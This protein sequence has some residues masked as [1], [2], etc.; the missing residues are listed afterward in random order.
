MN[1]NI[2][3]K[4]L[5]FFSE[6]EKIAKEKCARDE[7]IAEF[8]QPSAGVPEENPMFIDGFFLQPFKNLTTLSMSRIESA[9]IKKLADSG[10]G[11]EDSKGNIITN[12][13]V[14][15]EEVKTNDVNI[16]EIEFVVSLKNGLKIPMTKSVDEFRS[17]SW[18][19]Y[20][21]RLHCDN[22]H[23]FKAALELLLRKNEVVVFTE[24]HSPGWYEENGKWN[25]FNCKTNVLGE[26]SSIKIVTENAGA[27]KVNEREENL[28][29]KFWE[30]QNLTRGPQALIVMAY[31]ILASLYS[32]FKAAG[33]LPKGVLALIGPQ[34]TRKTSLALVLGKLLERSESMTPKYNM[35]STPTSI[36]EALEDFKD[37][38]L[39][40][41]DLSPS[42]DMSHRRQ[43]ERTLE[44]VV[45]IF[46]D[47]NTRQRS[48]NYAKAY[49]PKGL[50]ILTGEYMNAV[51]STLSRMIVLQVDTDTVDL[52]VL[53]Y[54]QK[55]H[56]ILPGFLWN[57]LTFC[58]KK[59]T[60]IINFLKARFGEKRMEVRGKYSPDRLGEYRVEL[61]L[62]MEILLMYLDQLN[63]FDAGILTSFASGFSFEVDCVLKENQKMQK[64]KQPFSQVVETIRWL[65]L[66]ERIYNLPE[67]KSEVK[68]DFYKDDKNL[69]LYPMAFLK[70]I[71]EYTAQCGEA[72]SIYN[73]SYLESVLENND[74]IVCRDEVKNKGELCKRRS[75]KLPKAGKLGDHRRF[76]IVPLEH[77]FNEDVRQNDTSTLNEK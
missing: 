46:G 42:E 74:A 4:A 63:C 64:V 76:Y 5:E 50:A 23:E 67:T 44:H 65:L 59:Q 25:Y 35:R 30:M 48:K 54:Y 32:I 58:A 45:R 24:Y 11:I 14:K 75:L 47:A 77:I 28:A 27:Y 26:Q 68:R 13:L 21:A 17:G 69:Y 31:V 34:S 16:Q 6:D 36:D 29:I 15:I 39:I 3:S 66:E 22:L 60:E 51:A 12:F 9:K 2:F 41:D 73:I 62:A 38:V 8:Q 57:F 71:E 70:S 1:S 72:T 56:H 49:E 7:I 10:Y 19:A 40:V 53:S 43:L 61:E 20:D 52:D 33:L 37:S 18:Y 55:N